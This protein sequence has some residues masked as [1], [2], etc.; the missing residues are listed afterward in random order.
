MCVR[1]CVRACECVCQSRYVFFFFLLLLI[2]S[3]D[4]FFSSTKLFYTSF[5]HFCLFFSYVRVYLFVFYLL[6]VF[7][8]TFHFFFLWRRGQLLPRMRVR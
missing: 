3:F 6:R 5:C 7:A 2:F 8:V 1:A 4:I